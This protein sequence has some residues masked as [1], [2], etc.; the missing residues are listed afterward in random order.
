MFSLTSWEMEEEVVTAAVVTT[1]MLM[2]EAQQVGTG[3]ILE[4][5][6]ML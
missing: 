1:V 6:C 5:H 2:M 3:R 4:L